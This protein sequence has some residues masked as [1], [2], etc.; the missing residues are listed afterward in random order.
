MEH[1]MVA[2]GDSV[3]ERGLMDAEAR[4]RA[5]VKSGKRIQPTEFRDALHHIYD[6]ENQHRKRL[7][8]SRYFPLRNADSDGRVVGGIV[9]ARGFVS[10]EGLDVADLIGHRPFILDRSSLDG[11][12]GL[13]GQGIAMRWVG[14]LPPPSQ[15]HRAMDRDTM[16]SERVAGR[17][18]MDTF[19]DAMSFFACVSSTS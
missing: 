7:S 9:Y 8:D 10:H 2:L 16:Y 19:T 14:E 6:L 13:D 18:V 12:D 17:D 3:P 11:D 4:L 5:W 15:Q 1:T